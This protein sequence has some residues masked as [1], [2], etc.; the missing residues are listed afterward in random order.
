MNEYESSC[1]IQPALNSTMFDSYFHFFGQDK[2]IHY[3]NAC[4]L[5]SLFFSARSSNTTQERELNYYITKT[6]A[7]VLLSQ[8]QKYKTP[9]VKDDKEEELNGRTGNS[10]TSN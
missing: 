9:L 7:L 10:V 1:E 3:T 5:S 6:V 8:Q 2:I 4:T